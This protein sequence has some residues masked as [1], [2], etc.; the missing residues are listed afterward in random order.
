MLIHATRFTMVHQKLALCI[1]EYISL[2]RKDITSY[3][4]LDKPENQSSNIKKIKETFETRCNDVEF[5]WKEVIESINSIIETVIIR[6]VHQKKSVELEYRDDC[7]TNVIVIG[8]TS[9]SRGYTLE[10]LSVSYFLRR[11]IFYDTLMQ[12]G[13]WFG[14]REGYEDLCKIY[15]TENMKNNFKR[16]IEATEDLFEDFRAME[17]EKKDSRRFWTSCSTTPR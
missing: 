7:V 16:I 1:E 11:T 6:E 13:R 9:L 14:Y 12:M 8:G 17:N 10:G 15:M 3:G 5:T 4:L 2:L